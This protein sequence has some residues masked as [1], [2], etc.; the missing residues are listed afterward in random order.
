MLTANRTS[1]CLF[2]WN[3][4]ERTR[5]RECVLAREG[6]RHRKRNNE[7]LS[8]ACEVRT[9]KNHVY[10]S[11]SPQVSIGLHTGRCCASYC[12]N[13]ALKLL[14]LYTFRGCCYGFYGMG[15]RHLMPPFNCIWAYIEQTEKCIVSNASQTFHSVPFHLNDKI[16]CAF[17][18]KKTK[19]NQ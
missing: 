2:S 8:V 1:M 14:C 15:N 3:T 16:V 5:D 19:S 11:V 7:K 17:P 12:L 6:E 18:K 10:D 13:C 4:E 9:E